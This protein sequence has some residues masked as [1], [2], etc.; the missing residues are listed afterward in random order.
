MSDVKWIQGAIAVDDRG[1][2]RFVNDFNFEGV[3]RFYAVENHRQGYVRAWHGHKKEAKY[4]YCARGAAVVGA[5][6]MPNEATVAVCE[7]T[8]RDINFRPDWIRSPKGTAEKYFLSANKP[9]VLYIPPGYANGFKT[10]TN[11]TLVMFF[12]TS[13]L[14]DSKGDD[15]RF[16]A[17]TWDIWDV[18]ER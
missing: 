6:P 17:R 3:K 1:S 7:E 15:Y 5:V 2:L 8:L 10:L 9:G 14:E 18:E 12:S 11:D 13:T 4:V 16:P